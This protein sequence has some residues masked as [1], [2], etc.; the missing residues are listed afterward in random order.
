MQQHLWFETVSQIGIKSSAVKGRGDVDRHIPSSSIVSVGNVIKLERSHR[1]VGEV[2]T[3]IYVLSFNL[4][5]IYTVDCFSFPI[6]CFSFHV[7]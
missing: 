4:N 1:N 2:F 6:D 7:T 5:T 3:D